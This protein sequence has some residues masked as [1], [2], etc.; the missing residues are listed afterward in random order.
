MGRFACLE[1]ELISLGFRRVST[2]LNED[3]SSALEHFPDLNSREYRILPLY[4]ALRKEDEPVL[5]IDYLMHGL[6]LKE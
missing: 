1:D 4:I 3:L 2:F 5:D 6:Y